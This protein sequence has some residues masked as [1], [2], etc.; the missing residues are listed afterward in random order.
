MPPC[1]AW[2]APCSTRPTKKPL[3]VLKASALNYQCDV[4]LGEVEWATTQS[5]ATRHDGTE[6]HSAAGERR[7]E[8]KKKPERRRRR[9]QCVCG[10]RVA[11]GSGLEENKIFVL[12]A[13]LERKHWWDFL[14]VKMLRKCRFP[15]W[16]RPHW[17][18]PPSTL[19]WLS[20]PPCFPLDRILSGLEVNVGFSACKT[21]AEEERLELVRRPRLPGVRCAWQPKPPP[22]L[23]PAPLHRGALNLSNLCTP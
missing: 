18:L 8:R 9:H 2:R 16:L 19:N 5:G 13:L 6:E 20:F 15:V 22:P 12:N 23:S 14:P 10:V 4:T 1:S 11:E 3:K 17:L 21:A 7:G